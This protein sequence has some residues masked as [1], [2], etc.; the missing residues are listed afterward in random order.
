QLT[1]TASCQS[2]DLDCRRRQCVLRC[3]PFFVFEFLDFWLFGLSGSIGPSWD[4]TSGILSWTEC[5]TAHLSPGNELLVDDL[6]TS[7]NR[8]LGDPGFLDCFIHLACSG[9]Y[10]SFWSS[11][12]RHAP[13]VSLDRIG[14]FS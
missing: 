6:R 5:R 10:S 14:V 2:I 13:T 1:R 8:A 3:V 12:K 7:S 4:G 9:L 11:S